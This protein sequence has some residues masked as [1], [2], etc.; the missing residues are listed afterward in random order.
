MGPGKHVLVAVDS[1]RIW[2]IHSALTYCYQVNSVV[3]PLSAC[4]SVSHLVTPAKT[5]E[6]IEMQFASMTGEPRERPVTYS[7]P[8]RANTVLCLFNTIQPSGLHSY[9]LFYYQFCVGY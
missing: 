3:C 2:L 4:Q 7:G 6:A 5:A 8:L 1:N 9:L